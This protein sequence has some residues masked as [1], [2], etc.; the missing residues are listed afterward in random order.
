MVTLN[1]DGTLEGQGVNYYKEYEPCFE[2]M[3]KL[4]VLGKG[5]AYTCIDDYVNLNH[6]ES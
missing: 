6:E 2:E 4:S 5:K 3:V 1:P